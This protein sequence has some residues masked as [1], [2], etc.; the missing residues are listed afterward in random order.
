MHGRDL[1]ALFVFGVKWMS[2]ELLIIKNE[3]REG[4]V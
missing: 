3:L 2:I 4:L 1:L